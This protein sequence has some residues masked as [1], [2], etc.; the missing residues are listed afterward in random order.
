MFSIGGE[1]IGLGYSSI[2]ISSA[3][4]SITLNNTKIISWKCGPVVCDQNRG[5]GRG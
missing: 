4:H 3:G 5:K 1:G 2:H